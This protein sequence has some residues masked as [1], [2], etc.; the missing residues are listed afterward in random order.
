[1]QKK[2]YLHLGLHKTATSSFQNSCFNNL[3]ELLSQGFDYPMFNCGKE[4]I[5]A[6]ENHS[7]PF[8]SL[9]CSNPEYYPVNLRLGLGSN[10]LKQVHGL[11]R[12][13][14]ERALHSDHQLILSGED[15]TSLET[16]QIHNLLD[17]L[18]KSR[19]EI[20]PIA[21]VRQPYT[22]HCSQLQ[23]QIKDGTPMTYWHHCPQRERIEKLDSIFGKH[24]SWIDFEASCQHPQGPVA[25]LMATMGIN[26]KK[27]SITGKNIG[28][29]NENIRIQ[30]FLN[31]REPSIINGKTN[32]HH[33]RVAPFSG[34][35]FRL[36]GEEVEALS[37][38]WDDPNRTATLKEHLDHES[39]IIQKALGDTWHKQDIHARTSGLDP[40]YPASTY[41]LL[42]II[43]LFLQDDNKPNLYSLPIADIHQTLITS[44]TKVIQELQPI[45]YQH[46]EAFI[47]IQKAKTTPQTPH[48]ELEDCGIPAA[49]ASALS[50][51]AK[52]WINRQGNHAQKLNPKYF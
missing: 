5:A 47:S 42:T 20:I 3:K 40:T 51:I 41:L 1:M 10:Q 39:E 4:S 23:Q 22:Y 48:K 17:N 34:N 38:H 30:N 2:L 9:F 49:A 50:S 46:A 21:A 36:T 35:Q 14:I 15:I 45:N 31:E 27:V 18:K 24:I 44:G 11:Y 26:I 12:Q 8:Y 6:F 7:I 19:R 25:Y 28:R 32:P 33:I 43:G 52:T 37:P 16:Q 29:C 13:Q